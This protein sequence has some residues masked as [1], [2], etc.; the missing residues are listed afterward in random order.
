MESNDNDTISKQNRF[1]VTLFASIT[2]RNSEKSDIRDS[3]T[4]KEVSSMAAST[5]DICLAEDDLDEE[6]F[7]PNF[8]MKAKLDRRS[9]M[10]RQGS[11]R[12]RRRS[13]ARFLKIVPEGDDKDGPIYQGT[14]RRS[15]GKVY[16]NAIRMNA[17]NRINASN[18]WSLNLIDHLDRFVEP[19]FKQRPGT[20]EQNEGASNARNANNLESGVNFTKAS[21]TLDA[22][23]KI[24]SYRVDDVHLTSYKVL[25]NLNRTNGNKKNKAN[26]SSSD[27]SEE[28]EGESS[29]RKKSRANANAVD[30]LEQNTGE[31]RSEYVSI[32]FL[33]NSRW[34]QLTKFVVSNHS[35]TCTT[36]RIST[37]INLMPPLTLIH[38]FTRCRRHSTRV[39]QKGFCSQIWVWGLLDATLY[40]IL[41]WIMMMLLPPLPQWRIMMWKQVIAIPLSKYQV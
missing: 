8:S 23:V 4:R 11:S 41:P 2:P 13:S 1:T 37:F 5:S 17:E 38:C 18:S 15:L 25:A 20:G 28:N 31:F 36:K 24:Y 16:S 12:R 22:S 9:L 35:F 21:C 7:D 10:K 27:H 32:Y 33:I 40:S 39:E 26:A 34:F 6:N 30:T 29:S 14:S 19:E 3:I